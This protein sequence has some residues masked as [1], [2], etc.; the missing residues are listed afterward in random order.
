MSELIQIH[1]MAATPAEAARMALDAGVDIELP[2]FATYDTLVEQ[3][4]QGTVS[5]KQIDRAA[6]NILRA[7]FLT[8]LFDDP[9]VDP[10]AAE[11]ITNNTEHQ[12]LA[13]KAA[14]ESLIL[15]KNENH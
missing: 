10:E 2:F 4:K 13:L 14:R 3:V 11:K 7:K 15:L 1:H 8:G 12:K 9:F 6:G 5:E